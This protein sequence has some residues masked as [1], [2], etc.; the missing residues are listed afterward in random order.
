MF[1]SKDDS[2]ASRA[3]PI[4]FLT[5]SDGQLKSRLKL[6][7]SAFG[8]NWM[9]YKSV[10][11]AE[12]GAGVAEGVAES[13]SDPS[14]AALP[15]AAAASAAATAVAPPAAA[16]AGKKAASSRSKERK[17]DPTARMSAV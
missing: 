12:A 5:P 8:L 3:C 7:C 6:S 4:L 15:A 17:K 9:W 11:E 13:V 16:E 14:D 2:S 1:M 10:P